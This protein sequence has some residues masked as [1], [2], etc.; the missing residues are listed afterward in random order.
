[1]KTN[2]RQSLNY[3]FII[4]PYILSHGRKTNPKWRGKRWRTQV[5]AIQVVW[6]IYLTIEFTQTA[7]SGFTILLPC[8]TLASVQYKCTSEIGFESFH[9]W[10]SH[11]SE[12][13]RQFSRDGT[14]TIKQQLMRLYNLC[15]KRWYA[16]HRSSLVAVVYLLIKLALSTL[17][18][19]FQT[20][21]AWGITHTLN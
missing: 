3:I 1:M 9:L 10:C 16:I 6:L 2:G 12:K 13:N 8:F 5:N 4:S 15:C 19:Q 21:S 17:A 18:Q 14:T 7:L 20:S 11:Y